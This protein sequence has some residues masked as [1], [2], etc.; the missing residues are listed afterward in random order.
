MKK[1]LNFKEYIYIAS[2]LFGLFFGAGNLIFPV[3]MGQM[4]GSN[5]WPA[6]LGF[7]VTGVGLPL[8]GV[9]A[10]GISRS[11]G[12]FELGSR[13]GK[14]YSMFFT[15]ALYLTIGPFFA[16]PRCANT[17]F[18]VGLENILPEGSNVQLCL[19]LFSLVFF[20]F[21]LF[22]SLRPGKIL[23]WVGKILNPGFLLFLAILVV[24]AMLNPSATVAE[25]VPEGDYATQSFF[26][27]FLEGYNTMD[28]LASLAFGI[29]VVRV[30]NGLGVEEPNEVASST[31]KSGIFSCTFMAVI[32]IAITIVGT[33]SR[34]LFA[35]SANGGIALA[36]IAQHYLGNVGLI[37]LAC[38]VTLACL[39]TS[40]GLITSCAETF[41]GLFAKGPSYKLWTIIFSVASFLFANIGLNGIISYSI[42]VLMFLYPLAITLILLSL[43]GRFFNYD[44]TVFI[45][46]T[47]LTL[48]ASIYDLIVSL[49]EWL[50]NAVGGPAIKAFMLKL[51]PFAELGLGW[52]CPAL[53]GL[54]IGLVLYGLKVHGGKKKPEVK[55]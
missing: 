42:P 2:M 19:F 55:A 16:I 15:C 5:V 47:V 25:V 30:I 36:Q 11:S 24:V 52:L 4:A 9:A 41:S 12:L 27:G 29:V 10:L 3:H 20:G 46:T 45:C 18:T 38:T 17:A 53:L 23:V 8:L 44:R 50:F 43:F 14:P 21:A 32:Y 31:V 1:K 37:I 39:K 35:T 6:I 33:Q 54:I 49:P 51:L 22:F 7:L 40:V 48:I 34:G 26:T 13:V 28:A